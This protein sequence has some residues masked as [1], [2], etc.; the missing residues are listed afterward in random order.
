MIEGNFFLKTKACF[1]LYVLGM[2]R[3]LLNSSSCILLYPYTES[4]LFINYHTYSKK[5]I[6]HNM[7]EH[8]IRT[9]ALFL[10]KSKASDSF[11]TPNTKL[12]YYTSKTWQNWIDRSVNKFWFMRWCMSSLLR[13]DPVH[14][15]YVFVFFFLFFFF[16]YR[17]ILDIMYRVV[18]VSI[19]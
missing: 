4:V 17:C 12:T 10:V 14:I 18:L 3:L 7:I 15:M 9:K 19:R 2:D 8:Y 1:F 11:I 13:R 6:V 5:I 16:W